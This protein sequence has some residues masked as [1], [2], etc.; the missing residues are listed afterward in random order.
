M[1]KTIERLVLV[2]SLAL[3]GCSGGNSINNTTTGYDQTG[4]SAGASS[5]DTSVGGTGGMYTGGSTGVGAA[6]GSGGIG[7]TGGTGGSDPCDAVTLESAMLGPIDGSFISPINGQHFELGETIN[8]GFMVPY[9]DCFNADGPVTASVYLESNGSPLGIN[10]EAVNMQGHYFGCPIN[11]ADPAWSSILAPG[12]YKLVYTAVNGA[13]PGERESAEVGVTIDPK[14]VAPYFL[15]YTINKNWIGEPLEV[16]IKTGDLDGNTPLNLLVSSDLLEAITVDSVTGSI[17]SDVL[18]TSGT[19]TL[20]ATVVDSKGAST[21]ESFSLPI[22][23]RE[24]LMEVNCTPDPMWCPDGTI[25]IHVPPAFADTI[26]ASLTTY[27]PLAIG[28][29]KFSDACA[30]NTS[31]VDGPIKNAWDGIPNLDKLELIV[32][33]KDEE[34]KVAR[35]EHAL[36]G[37]SGSLT[38]CGKDSAL[39][40]GV[41]VIQHN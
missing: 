17:T 34:I 4:G 16:V 15:E 37:G 10:C 20:D 29:Q 5:S 31:Q 41:R 25:S 30:D 23:P 14:N 38:P 39:V 21:S 11:T 27:D 35:I 18:A 24:Y 13:N 26:G 9:L 6:G 33:D 12:S 40:V 1:V 19:Y 8:S 36:V 3:I 32:Y 2:S 22:G 7:G 28:T